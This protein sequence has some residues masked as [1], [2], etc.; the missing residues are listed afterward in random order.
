MLDLIQEQISVP[1]S[2][3]TMNCISDI[4]RLF[5][6]HATYECFREVGIGLPQRLHTPSDYESLI[7]LM[8]DYN[9]YQV[10][11]K[12]RYGSSGSGVVALRASGRHGVIALTTTEVT[13]QDAEGVPLFY[14]SRKIR[15]Y[16]SLDEV[17]LLVDTLCKYQVHV[18][19]WIP[20]ATLAGKPYDLRLLT[21]D[22]VPSHSIIR[23]GDS[24]ITN[25]HLLNQRSDSRD[26]LRS[27]PELTV[28]SLLNQA[29]SAAKVFPK[30]LHLGLDMLIARNERKSVILEANAFGDLLPGLLHNGV[31]VYTAEIR[32]IMAKLCSSATGGDKSVEPGSFTD[33]TGAG[34][35]LEELVNHA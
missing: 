29:M 1:T 6:K 34:E 23:L 5:D 27:L 31:D 11:V 24:P 17:R 3:G 28:R 22:G 10:F 4:K 7:H 30:S 9:V 35:T 33:G 32:A 21:I 19:R 13:E 8:H 18:E 25:L 26:V 16:S 14:N 20:K 2:L 15:R 12:L